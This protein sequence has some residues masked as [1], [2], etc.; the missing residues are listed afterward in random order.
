L[1]LEQDLVAQALFVHVEV[2]EEGEEKKE[3]EEE[4]EQDT[5]W[6]SEEEEEVKAKELEGAFEPEPEELEERSKL[7]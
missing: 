2:G 3:E 1:L 7:G 5:W 6:L 4:E